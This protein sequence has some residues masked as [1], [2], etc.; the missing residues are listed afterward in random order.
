MNTSTLVGIGKAFAA[1]AIEV[2]ARQG[3]IHYTLQGDELFAQFKM[4]GETVDIKQDSPTDNDVR[5]ILINKGFRRDSITKSM[6]RNF[7]LGYI[8]AYVNHITTIG[9]NG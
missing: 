8:T 2:N 9:N 5:A 7:Q 1:R 3:I 4:G 6:I